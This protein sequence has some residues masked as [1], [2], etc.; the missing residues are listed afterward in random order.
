MPRSRKKG[1]YIKDSLYKK[2]LKASNEKS[3]KI[4]TTWS[5]SSVI[6]PEMIGLTISVHNGKKHIPL[7][8]TEQLIGHK[9]GEFAYT[10]TF[11]SH[12]KGK[13]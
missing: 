7:F 9:L 2:V 8:I 6:I 12:E 10:R 13:K 5:R 3:K 11:K 4:I 1:P